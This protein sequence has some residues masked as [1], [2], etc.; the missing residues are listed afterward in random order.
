MMLP[1]PLGL[2]QNIFFLST[3]LGLIPSTILEFRLDDECGLL[4]ANTN[5]TRTL[6]DGLTVTVTV[7][8]VVHHG[9]SL[10][11]CQKRQRARIKY[12]A[13]SARFDICIG[14]YVS[15]TGKLRGEDALILGRTT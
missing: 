14:M 1:G 6:S 5:G 12:S 9:E 8:F 4:Y 11:T 7:F 13:K 15:R 3:V 2:G 10:S